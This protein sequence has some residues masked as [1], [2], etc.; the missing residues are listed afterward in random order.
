MRRKFNKKRTDYKKIVDGDWCVLKI[1]KIVYA[2]EARN[3]NKVRRVNS[4]IRRRTIRKSLMAISRYFNSKSMKPSSPSICAL[5]FTRAWHH[6]GNLLRTTIIKI[7]R[8]TIA[9]SHV[10]SV[11]KWMESKCQVITDNTTDPLNMFDYLEMHTLPQAKY[12][13]Q[14]LIHW[15]MVDL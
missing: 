1:L 9:S 3:R 2:G 7:F 14:Y 12:G 4:A 5:V 10:K 13:G 6:W 15:R 11:A 8:E